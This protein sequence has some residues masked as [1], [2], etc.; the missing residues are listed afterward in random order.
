VKPVLFADQAR[1]DLAGIISFIAQDAPDAAARVESLLRECATRLGQFS[2][3]G[4]THK[5]GGHR[6]LAVARTPYI[7]VY[8]EQPERITI[9]RIWHGACGWPPVS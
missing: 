1:R 4:I 2:S 7:L 5:A 9:L 6:L 3:M 8:R